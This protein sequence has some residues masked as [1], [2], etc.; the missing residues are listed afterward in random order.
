MTNSLL[1]PAGNCYTSGT[2]L[3][4]GGEL[5]VPKVP[6]RAATP[7][8]AKNKMGPKPREHV[9]LSCM[10]G[11]SSQKCELCIEWA[12]YLVPGDV[13]PPLH[14][15]VARTE[16]RVQRPLPFRPCFLRTNLCRWTWGGGYSATV[17]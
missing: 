4:P 6:D 12:G 16:R 7:A 15:I 11:F 9:R 8:G 17:V 5:S 3:V 1:A 13:L 14:N 10:K 2:T